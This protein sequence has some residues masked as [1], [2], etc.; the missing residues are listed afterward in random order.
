MLKSDVQSL[1]I[2]MICL[3]IG[4][5]W[6]NFSFFSHSNLL[7][8]MRCSSDFE[9][10]PMGGALLFLFFLSF[11]I[12]SV[13][14]TILCLKSGPSREGP[15]GPPVTPLQTITLFAAPRLKRSH[16]DADCK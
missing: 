5:T 13:S 14:D 12:C 6:D 9:K 15:E 1:G 8:L 16:F 10:D 11:V 2:T 4:T 7:V 3:I